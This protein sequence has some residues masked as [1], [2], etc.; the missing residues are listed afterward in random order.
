MKHKAEK[1]LNQMRMQ[2]VI[3]DKATMSIP[4]YYEIKE[5]ITELL[6]ERV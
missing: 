5:L 2:V 6:K 3:S 1:L 4:L